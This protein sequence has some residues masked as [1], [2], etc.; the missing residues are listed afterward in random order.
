MINFVKMNFWVRTKHFFS[1]SQ[2]PLTTDQKSVYPRAHVDNLATFKRTSLRSSWDI[3]FTRKGWTDNSKTRNRFCCVA[4]DRETLQGPCP[5]LQ[6][7]N[8]FILHELNLLW[9]TE[10]CGALFKNNKSFISYLSFSFS[11][12]HATSSKFT[13]HILF[14]KLKRWNWMSLTSRLCRPLLGLDPGYLVHL[15]VPG[16]LIRSA[17]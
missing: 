1:R 4:W 6:Y 5:V 16:Y 3:A 10:F 17:E 14:E 8:H 11:D 15:E 7:T 2:R 9:S 12:I 13:F